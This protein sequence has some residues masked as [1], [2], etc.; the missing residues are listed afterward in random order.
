VPLL[1]GPFHYL[2]AKQIRTSKWSDG[3]H[4]G[5]GGWDE[6]LD[7]ASAATDQKTGPAEMRWQALGFLKPTGE[8]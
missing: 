2:T 4:P 5:L 6:D 3:G 8:K 1:L 7:Q